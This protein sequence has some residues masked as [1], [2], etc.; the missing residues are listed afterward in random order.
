LEYIGTHVN[1][2]A[3]RAVAISITWERRMFDT[4]GGALKEM[5]PVRLAHIERPLKR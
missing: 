5:E 3:G 1:H 2:P 4:R